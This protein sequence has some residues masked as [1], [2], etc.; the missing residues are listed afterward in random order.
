MPSLLRDAGLTD[1]DAAFATELGYGTLRMQGQHDHVLNQVVDRPL[2]EIDPPVLSLLRL[3]VHQLH[4]MR[5]PTHAA[6]SATVELAR[7]VVGESRASFVNAVLRRIGTKEL[8]QWLV[9]A[10]LSARY[11]HPQWIID[12]FSAARGLED[13]EGLLEADNTPAVVTLAVRD[14]DLKE[15]LIKRGGRPGRLSP[16]AIHWQ[17]VLD[18]DGLGSARIGVQD[19]GSQIVTLALAAVPLEQDREWLDMCAGPG[20]KA[21]LLSAIAEERD[22]AIRLVANEVSEHRAQLVRPQVRA[23]TTVIVGDARNLPAIDPGYDRIL[24]DAPCSGLGALRRRPEARWRRTA[25]DV[26]SL[27][28]L[29]LELLTHGLELLAPGGVL[30]YITCSPHL[31]ETSQIVEGALAKLEGMEIIP[32]D[33]PALQSARRGP[34]VQLWPDRDGTDGMFLALIRRTRR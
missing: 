29:Q 16:N 8:A 33:L 1:R 17:G 11:S 7:A 5:V 12:A 24:L 30:A 10:P 4:S 31:A 28:P 18:M 13:L 14:R 19:E 27:R 23:N 22:P 9:D 6:V 34:Y 3:G 26:G 21:A 32:V 20:G 15:N 25:R 2:N